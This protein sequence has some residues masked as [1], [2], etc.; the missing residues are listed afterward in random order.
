MYASFLNQAYAISKTLIWTFFRGAQKK[1]IVP[2]LYILDFFG[3]REEG[4][5]QAKLEHM[6]FEEPPFYNILFQENWENGNTPR[7][8]FEEDMMM[9][10]KKSRI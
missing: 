5:P 4:L 10:G 6:G 1:I 2:V 3:N 9:S 7:E 8:K